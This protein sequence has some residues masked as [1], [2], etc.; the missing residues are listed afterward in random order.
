MCGQSSFISTVPVFGGFGVLEWAGRRKKSKGYMVKK[1]RIVLF[2]FETCRQLSQQRRVSKLGYSSARDPSLRV[3]RMC[4][5]LKSNKSF[6][7]SV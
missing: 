1:I 7:V 6:C 4:D 5:F 3:T 2:S